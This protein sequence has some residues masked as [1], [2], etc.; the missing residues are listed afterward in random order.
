MIYGSELILFQHKTEML[1]LVGKDIYTIHISFIE[2]TFQEI[3]TN[4]VK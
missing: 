3:S 2:L 4:F 1:Y